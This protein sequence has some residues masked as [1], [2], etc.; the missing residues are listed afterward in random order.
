MSGTDYKGFWLSEGEFV[1][2]C[3]FRCFVFC[4]YFFY[5]GLVS[6]EIKAN[7]RLGLNLGGWAKLLTCSQCG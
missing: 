1:C 5:N 6:G 4:F 3:V 7:V 2:V